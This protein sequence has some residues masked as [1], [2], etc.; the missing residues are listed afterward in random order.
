MV[1]L[2]RRGQNLNPRLWGESKLLA[3][4]QIGLTTNNCSYYIALGGMLS[5]Y[6]FVSCESVG[7][8]V[9]R[10]TDGFQRRVDNNHNPRVKD[11][12]KGEFRKGSLNRNQSFFSYFRHL[13]RRYIFASNF[14]TTGLRSSV[15]RTFL[16][17]KLIF[18]KKGSENFS[19][20]SI[21]SELQP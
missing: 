13:L 6:Y 18:Y 19:I 4:S 17:E 14:L 5:C 8:A 12:Y 1:R 11:K 15:I 7:V 2:F 21:F 16:V 9:S 20:G 10:G 3:A